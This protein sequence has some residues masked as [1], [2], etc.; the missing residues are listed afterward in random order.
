M[1]ICS[2]LT[3]LVN[4]IVHGIKKYLIEISSCIYPFSCSVDEGPAVETLVLPS[5]QSL[6]SAV[7]TTNS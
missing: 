3:A 5:C 1:I 6:V 4:C 2:N 7:T